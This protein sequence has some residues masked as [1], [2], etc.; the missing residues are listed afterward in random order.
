[1]SG[2]GNFKYSKELASKNR[3]RTGAQGGEYII[4]VSLQN[5]E[6][7]SLLFFSIVE[8][9]SDLYNT[10]PEIT[11]VKNRYNKTLHRRQNSIYL[12]VKKGFTELLYSTQAHCSKYITTTGKKEYM[13]LIP[14]CKKMLEIPYNRQNLRVFCLKIFTYLEMLQSIGIVPITAQYSERDGYSSLYTQ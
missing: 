4:N 3:E 9:V 13:T 10:I 2:Q 8:A 14:E 1:M 12:P 6:R 11:P 7:I 5:N